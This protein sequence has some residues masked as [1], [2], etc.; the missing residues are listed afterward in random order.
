M[1]GAEAFIIPMIAAGGKMGAAALG[2]RGGGAPPPGGAPGMGQTGTPP[3]STVSA[4]GTAAQTPSANL[5]SFSQSLMGGPTLAQGQVPNFQYQ[6]ASSMGQP[7]QGPPGAPK[8]AAGGGPIPAF[9]Y[10][11]ASAT[12]QPPQAPP[13]PGAPGVTL[14]GGKIP[15]FQYQPGTSLG[16]QAPTTPAP[17]TQA[18]QD[19]LSDLSTGMASGWD[20]Y[21]FMRQEKRKSIPKAIAANT[22]PGGPATTMKLGQAT[23]TR[24]PMERYLML[25]RGF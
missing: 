19:K 5:N 21:K 23:S 8:P 25:M 11:Q 22:R 2:N 10:Q 12:G 15:G 7:P 17:S 24:S 13:P 20:V 3:I 4:S 16:Q 1:S 14:A 9:K 18:A 6:N